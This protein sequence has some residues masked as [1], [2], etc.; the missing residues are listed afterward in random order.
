MAA[1]QTLR[2]KAAIVI[3]AF[4]A[5]AL[6]AFILTDLLGSGSSIF[7]DRET[8]GVIDGQSVKYPD[9]QRKIEEA[10]T[11]AKM[12][13]QGSLSE[14]QQNQI[15][16]GVWRQLISEIALGKLYENAGVA[17]S[18]EEIYDM[19]AGEHI[20]PMLAQLFVNQ[21]TGAYD[22]SMAVNFLQQKNQD[23]QASFYWKNVETSLVSNRLMEKYMSLI[24]KSCYITKAQV[25]VE[26]AKRA[27]T[28]DIC[29]VNVRYATLPDSTI[30]VSDS[31]VKDYYNAHKDYY[32]VDNSRDI[33]YVSFPIRPT[34]EDRADV[35][36]QLESLK[37]DFQAPETDAFRFAQM[38][39]E[40]PAYKV[41][42]KEAQLSSALQSFVKDAQVGEICGP[43]IEGETFKISK[44][45]EVAMRPDSVK[46][47]HILIPDDEKL[48]D[49]LM[50]AI[51]GGA[52]FAV[53]AR[54]YSKDQGSAV[55]GGDL[56]WFTDGRMVPEFNEAC[57]TNAKGAIVKV[58]TQFGY[59]II[60]VQDRGAEV[61]KYCFATIEKT[62]QFSNRTQQQVYAKAQQFATG[63]KDAKTFQT[64]VDSSNV[65]KRVA[66]NI[67]SNAQ[68]IN[69]I[70]HAREIVR[71]AFDSK[72]GSVSELFFCDDQIVIA[73]LTKETEK[74]YAPAADYKDQIVR[75][76]RNEKKADAVAKATQGKSLNEIAQL[77]NAKV[78]SASNV[79][80]ASNT[81]PGAG[82]EPAVVGKAISL[83]S[84][85]VFTAVQGNN[86]AFALQV[87]AR[88]A[89]EVTDEQVVSALEAQMRSLPYYIQQQVIDVE[90]EDNRIKFY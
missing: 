63:V 22:R 71:W 8:V 62:V 1:L 64:A 27:N 35:S 47:R 26:K 54:Q 78:D 85:K 3:T 9:F 73:L 82:L 55:N 70:A 14:Q 19:A 37:A 32:K 46:A 7:V 28:A 44:L 65:V 5:V 45:T 23:P 75:I 52:D 83:E 48:A 60:N 18:P 16:E 12:N 33:E 30:A 13:S 88:N 15:R 87:N 21:Q 61:K 59:H 6:L 38:N 51:K 2:N 79:S 49:S 42:Q 72:V 41:F 53:V 34:D 76:L 31:E 66:R 80:F 40:A 77:Y 67:L 90:V 10:E 24:Q 11:F 56:D 50:A 86:G 17:V 58:Q 89:E 69:N 20:S 84:G 57:F 74:G 39:S 68:S 43:Y 36:K 81:L 29:F 4:I 25:E